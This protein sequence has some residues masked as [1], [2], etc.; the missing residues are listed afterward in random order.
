VIGGSQD[1]GTTKG[2]AE[3]NSEFER[4]FG[5]DGVSVGISNPVN[6]VSHEY[7][8]YQYGNIYR[9]NEH[10]LPHMAYYIRPR[11]APES[12][13]FI[14]VFL[15][16]PDNTEQLY[17]VN[18]DRVFRNLSA[19]TADQDN[20]TEMTGITA[21]ANTDYITALGTTRGEYKA[22]QKSLFIGT[23]FGG[24]FRLDDPANADP[25]TVPV[26][27]SEGIT[28]SGHISS[29]SVNPRNDDTVLVTM[30]SYG[31]TN[32]WWTGN[33]NAA[34]PTWVNVEKNLT[35]PSVRSSAI[36]ITASGVEYFVGTSVGLFKSFNPVTGDWIQ[37]A[38]SSIGNAIVSS[39]FL[40]PADNRLL[41]GTY[42]YGMWSTSL[43]MP[44]VAAALP[45]T[46][47]AFTGKADGHHSLLEWSTS[48][49]SNTSH[50][51]IER[52]YDKQTFKKIGKVDASGHSNTTKHYRFVDREPAP[53][54]V[55]YRMKMMDKDQKF[56]WSETVMIRRQQKNQQLIISN[57]FYDH[58]DVR[59]H[60][61]PKGKIRVR[62]TDLSGK[63]MMTKEYQAIFQPLLQVSH[64]M[65]LTRG[66]YFLVVEAENETFTRKLTRM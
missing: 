37:E 58:I 14:T 1:N 17:Y 54:V 51:E 66:V 56:T 10:D 9:R 33:A 8:G 48:S 13:L 7:L 6:G 49:E 29:I 44:A 34:K 15:L 59:F 26:N 40:R 63:I 45:L 28:A 50:F 12:G 22:A 25:S 64:G 32:I 65:F 41:I 19:S 61:I 24:V 27:I 30:S 5:G 2:I 23:R 38:S 3:T 11:S 31:V 21:A 39:L 16:D 55:Y 36:A 4:V 62:L 60:E 43:S 20:W 42:G 18:G 35:L 46:L 47:T 52:G 57:P 53:S